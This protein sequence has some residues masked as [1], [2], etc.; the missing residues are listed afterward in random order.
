[1][2]TPATNPACRVCGH[3]FV[4]QTSF[5][6][7]CSPKCLGIERRAKARADINDRKATKA[8]LLAMKPRSHWLKL[9][10]VAF[11]RFIRTRD[12]SLPCI[13]CGRMHQGA[14]DA[15]HYL[16]TGARPELR[17]NEDNCHRQCVPCNQHLH[18]NL[19]LYRKGLIAR[20]GSPA[21]E[22]LEG[23]HPPSKW[24]VDRLKEIRAI[25]T[26]KTKSLL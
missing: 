14:H 26:A 19:L 15:G 2:L 12:A 24:T 5:H 9:A 10:Q 23:P 18:G 6:V 16:T 17:F 22:A 8:K 7:I 4:R 1:M 11:N 25:Y 3:G 21:V 13:S 20:I